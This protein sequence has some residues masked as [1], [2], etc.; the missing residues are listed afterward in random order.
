[1]FEKPSIDLH[2]FVT[3]AR[4]VEEEHCDAGSHHGVFFQNITPR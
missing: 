1:M 3:G 4:R 2:V